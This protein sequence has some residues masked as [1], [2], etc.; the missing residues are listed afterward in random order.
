MANPANRALRN[1]KAKHGK[2]LFAK[3][4]SEMKAKMVQWHKEHGVEHERYGCK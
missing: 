2:F 1:R 4:I 3:S